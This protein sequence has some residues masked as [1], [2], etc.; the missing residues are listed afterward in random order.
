MITFQRNSPN[1][2]DLN[3]AKS[4]EIKINQDQRKIKQQHIEENK[5]EVE[6]KQFDQSYLVKSMSAVRTQKIENNVQSLLI[7]S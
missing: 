7:Q 2:P 5:D 3:Q 4:F 6:N 1:N